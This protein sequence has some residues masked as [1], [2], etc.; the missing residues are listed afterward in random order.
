MLNVWTIYYMEK[1]C[2]FQDHIFWP[3]FPSKYIFSRSV[4]NS[5]I[6]NSTSFFKFIEN[7]ISNLNCFSKH[8]WDNCIFG[9]YL[10][11]SCSKAD[12]L[13]L[14]DFLINCSCLT[15]DYYHYFSRSN[16]FLR[17]VKTFNNFSLHRSGGS[18]F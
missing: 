16:I 17:I 2:K 13:S 11:L 14:E 7:S 12:L 15:V 9:E 6:C 5:E 10:R 18:F 3:S 1:F 4:L 8:P